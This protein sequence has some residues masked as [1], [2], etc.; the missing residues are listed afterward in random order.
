LQLNI[1]QFFHG[2]K[3]ISI[4]DAI[5]DKIIYNEV[6]VKF[7]FSDGFYIVGED[8]KCTEAYIEIKNCL[9]D[10]FSCYS[11]KRTSTKDGAKVTGT[12][13]ALETLSSLLELNKCRIE[14]FLELYDV[15]YLHW[16]GVLLPYKEDDLSDHIVIEICGTYPVTYSWI[17]K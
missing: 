8:E 2:E 6:C 10:D 14:L 4:C 17:Q 16:R 3:K 9:P 11:I 1:E 15:N 5:I 7:V 12:P 13:I